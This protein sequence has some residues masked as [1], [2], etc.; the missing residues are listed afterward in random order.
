MGR[1]SAQC[2]SS[3]TSVTVIKKHLG[4]GTGLREKEFIQ[5]TT[6]GYKS[7]I[8]GKPRE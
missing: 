2:C 8:V 1:N 6:P 7:I 3:F 4:A 5:L